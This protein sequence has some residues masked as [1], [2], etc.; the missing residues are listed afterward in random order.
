MMRM[1]VDCPRLRSEV[2]VREVARPA[3]EHVPFIVRETGQAFSTGI[4]ISVVELAS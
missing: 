4:W 3:L 2:T 1:H